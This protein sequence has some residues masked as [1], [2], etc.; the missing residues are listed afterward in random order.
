M[1]L[2][3]AKPAISCVGNA[4]SRGHPNRP[5]RTAPP[6]TAKFAE[7]LADLRRGDEIAGR[8]GLVASDADRR[9]RRFA[10]IIANEVVDALPVHQAS[11]ARESCT[12]ACVRSTIRSS[13]E[14][15][16]SWSPVSCRSRGPIAHPHIS[17]ARNHSIRFEGIAKSICKKPQ[18][19]SRPWKYFTGDNMFP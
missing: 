14:R 6:K 11:V 8:A 19:R 3:S 10:I 5:I 12:S 1:C 9:A 16:R 18:R 17:R 15:N 7:H 13:R 2:R 4:G